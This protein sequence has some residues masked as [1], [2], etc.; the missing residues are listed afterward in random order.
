MT[1]IIRYWSSSRRIY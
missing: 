1:Q